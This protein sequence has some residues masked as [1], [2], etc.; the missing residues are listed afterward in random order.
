MCHINGSEIYRHDGLSVYELDGLG[1]TACCQRLEDIALCLNGQVGLDDA[2]KCLYYVLYKY[3]DGE[4]QQ[5]S[6]LIGFFSKVRLLL[7][8]RS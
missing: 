3:I 4:D 1:S 7:N 5:F 8:Y 2:T 6:Q